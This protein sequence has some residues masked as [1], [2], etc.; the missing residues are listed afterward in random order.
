MLARERAEL[1]SR[2]TSILGETNDQTSAIITRILG[3]HGVLTSEHIVSINEATSAA[4][5]RF[6]T[7]T[8]LYAQMNAKK[9]ALDAAFAEF[10]EMAI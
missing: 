4:E 8:E 6:A 5:S 7:L 9:T 10:V 1:S 2:T 3:D